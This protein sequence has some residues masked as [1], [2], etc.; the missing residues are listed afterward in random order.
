VKQ[1]PFFHHF[2]QMGMLWLFDLIEAFHNVVVRI[3]PPSEARRSLWGVVSGTF[4]PKPPTE[5]QFMS[6]T[7]INV[8][9]GRCSASDTDNKTGDRATNR[10]IQ[11]GMLL[12][13][14]KI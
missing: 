1:P 5:S 12:R 4:H 10:A 11:R 14:T 8:M 2:A 3:S 9:L 13:F 7:L 6:S